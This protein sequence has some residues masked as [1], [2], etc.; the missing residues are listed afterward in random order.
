MIRIKV[1]TFLGLLV[2]LEA[3]TKNSPVEEQDNTSVL[4]GGPA[5]NKTDWW[6]PKAGISFDWNLEVANQ[7]DVYTTDV[8]DVDAFETTKE[9]VTALHAKGKKVIAYVSVG[10]LE[11][12]RTDGNLLPVEVIG[13]IYPEW[14]EE[15]WLD[16]HQLDKMKPWLINRFTMI[17][18]KGFD[19]IEPDNIDG[20]SATNTGFSISLDDTKKFCDYIITLSHQM[21][22]GIGQKNVGELAI[23]YSSKFDWALTEDAFNQGWQDNMKPYIIQNKPVFAVEYTDQTDQQFFSS[24]ICPKA[25]AMKYS[26]ILK[27]RHIDK[28][29][30]FCN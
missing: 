15:K 22:L 24:V 30:V 26:A 11:N 23:D 16:I 12:T 13:N 9:M 3:C 17:Q 4:P 20:Y 28:W 6:K 29:V 2:A 7:S 18:K 21:G 5:E 27:K 8:V 1:I 25:K 10:T 14:P 19:A